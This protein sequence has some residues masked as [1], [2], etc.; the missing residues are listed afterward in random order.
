MWLAETAVD[1]ET[2]EVLAE[3]GIKFTVL[4]PRQAKMYRALTGDGKWIGW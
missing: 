2:L 1:T 4:A 3:N